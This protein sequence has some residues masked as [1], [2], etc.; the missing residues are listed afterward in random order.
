MDVHPIR[1]DN[2]RFWPPPIYY[3]NIWEYRAYFWYTS[4]TICE[5]PSIR[6]TEGIFLYPMLSNSSWFYPYANST[7]SYVRS[8]YDV[9]CLLTK[10]LCLPYSRGSWFYP[11]VCSQLILCIKLD[12]HMIH[13]CWVHQIFSRSM[14]CKWLQ[15]LILCTHIHVRYPLS[16]SGHIPC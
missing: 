8:P 16:M 12:T 14:F 13:M 11:H 15:V 10:N 1:I 6:E 4:L 3:S 9:V 5:S 2:N 7:V